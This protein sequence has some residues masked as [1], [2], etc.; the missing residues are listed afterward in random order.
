MFIYHSE[1]IHSE[2]K[3]K[4][5][6]TKVH[7]V[8]IKGKKGK[9]SVIIYDHSGKMT[10][11]ASKSLTKKEIECIRTCTFIPGLFRDCTPCLKKD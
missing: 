5:G 3:N 9:K 7:S 6:R 10:R 2:F 8:S 1:Q 4:K 11:K